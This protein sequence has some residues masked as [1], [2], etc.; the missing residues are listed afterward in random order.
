MVLPF[1]LRAAC[2]AMLLVTLTVVTAHAQ[3]YPN[4]RTGGNYMHNYLLPPAASSTPWWPSWSPDGQWLAFA[5]DGS[6][7]RMRVTNGRADGAAEELLREKEFLS[8]PEWSPDGR[9][10]AYT[11]DDDGRSINVRVVNLATGVV[12]AVTTGAFVN[13]EPAW[14]PDGRRLAYVTTAPNGFYNIA[15][16]DITDGRP[17]STIQVTTDH[18]FGGPRLYFSDEDVHLSPAWSPDG[19]E[20]LFVSNRGIPLGSG[21]VWRAPVEADVMNGG[22]ARL[23]HK[24]ETLYRT[25]PQWSPDGKRFVYASHLGGQFTNL[26][27][28]PTVGGEPYKM[29]FGEYDAFLPRWSP[30]GEWIAYISNEQGLPQLKLLKAWGGEARLA[31][32][33]KKQWKTP[34]GR[35]DVRVVDERG[36]ETPA[37]VYHTASDGKPYTPSDAYERLSTLNRH[38]FHT[39]GR[40]TT[41]APPGPFRIEAMKG[42]EYAVTR[43]DVD[44][45]AGATT[46]VTVTL[47]RIVNL[48]AKGWRSGSNHV[49]MNYAGNLHNTPENIMLMNAAEDADMVSLQ[50]AN[51]DNRVLDYQHYVPGRDH[52]PLST[53]ERVMHVG[54]EYRPPFYGHISLFNLKE[55]LISPFVTGYEGTAVE[56]LYPSNTDIFRYAKQQGGIGG[57]VH[58]YNGDRDPLEA[59][60]GTAKTFPV[61]VALGAVSYH[62]LWSQSAGDAPLM[63]WYRILNT[64]FRVPVTG[65]E[66]SISNL[67]RVELVGSTRGYFNLG[68]APLTW[69]NWMK[70]LLAGRGF[71]T[72]GPLIEFTANKS[73]MPGEEIALPAAGGP[74]SFQATVSSAAPIR[75][76]EL[77][78]NGT[79]VHGIDVPDGAQTVTF[80]HTVQAAKSGWYSLRAVGADLTFPVENSRPLAVTNPIYV[81]V[82]GQPIRDKASAEYFVKWID[83]LTEMATAH[84]GWRSDKEK[85]HVLGQFKEARDIFVARATEA[86]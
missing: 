54:Q 26:F 22:R 70:A 42:F 65:G 29:T 32:V 73:V 82:G 80:A 33:T 38:L 23:I 68:S 56:S 66:D 15:V 21:G 31:L 50:I 25:R 86:R 4:A 17:G 49:H 27:V 5:M 58:P 47:K 3:N 48:K 41:E 84:P 46:T 53:A 14:S 43:Q 12:T 20:L 64:G 63:V 8:S 10:L 57:Y 76:V 75:R 45:K 69:A 71:V 61:D 35:I 37:R 51:K 2:G 83:T 60:L 59:G 1:A 18:K 30:D 40:Y 77:V 72:N 36:R 44:V 78:S 39:R 9:Y 85:T 16:T 24:E 34:M 28:L 52:H 13:I 55:H 11:A 62:E 81:T 74:V 79:V 67:H 19:K 7:W 6:L